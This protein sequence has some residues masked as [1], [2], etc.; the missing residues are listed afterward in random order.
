VRVYRIR[1]LRYEV[2]WNDGTIG[3]DLYGAEIMAVE[4]EEEQ[5]S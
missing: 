5:P 2:V 4:D 3:R 1:S